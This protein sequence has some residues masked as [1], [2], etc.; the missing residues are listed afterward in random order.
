VSRLPIQYVAGLARTDEMHRQAAVR[1]RFNDNHATK[2]HRS[3]G[4]SLTAG[5]RRLRV[6]LKGEIA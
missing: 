3:R 1:R 4:G 5:A 2:R 6:A